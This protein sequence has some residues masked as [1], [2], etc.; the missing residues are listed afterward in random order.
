PSDTT[1]PSPDSRGTRPSFTSA[2][3]ASRSVRPVRSGSAPGGPFETRLTIG[4][5]S[6]AAAIGTLAAAPLRATNTGAAGLIVG[7][8]P[9][10]R[11][12]ASAIRLKTGADTEPPKYDPP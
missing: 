11:S 12:V 6:S 9:R 4:S 3:I 7:P 5:L 8:T 10:Y 1:N 2:R